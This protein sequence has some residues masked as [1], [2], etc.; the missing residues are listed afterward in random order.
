MCMK[1]VLASIKIYLFEPED[2]K[3]G[4]IRVEEAARGHRLHGLDPEVNLQAFGHVQ[5]G[6]RVLREAQTRALTS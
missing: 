3:D 1:L 6:A 2:R 5:R 4:A